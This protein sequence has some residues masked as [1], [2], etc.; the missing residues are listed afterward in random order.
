MKM[1]CEPVTIIYGHALYKSAIFVG[2]V[3]G[4]ST[5][6]HIRLRRLFLAAL[7]SSLIRKR[8]NGF[9]KRS[10]CGVAL[11]PSSL[12]RTTSTP[13]SSGFA[14]LACGSFYEAVDYGQFIDFL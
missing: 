3:I 2:F 6:F 5:Y 14:R 4:S 1:G 12:R 8:K 11:H 13:H 7:I 10:G 9:V